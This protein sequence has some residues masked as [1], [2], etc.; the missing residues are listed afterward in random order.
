V[1]PRGDGRP[2]LARRRSPSDDDDEASDESDEFFDEDEVGDEP[3]GRLRA[4]DEGYGPDL[5]KDEVA[6]DVPSTAVRRRPKRPRCTSSS[7]D[8]LSKARRTCYEESG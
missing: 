2:E 5:E 7:P 8:V 4:E 1:R 3:S 6:E